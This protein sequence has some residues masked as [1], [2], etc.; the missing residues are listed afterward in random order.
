[1]LEVVRMLKGFTKCL[2]R[3]VSRW[4]LLQLVKK[5]ITSCL[6]KVNWTT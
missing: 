2:K 1:M 4:E 6:R 3:E 5:A